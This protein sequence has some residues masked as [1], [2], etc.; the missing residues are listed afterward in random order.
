MARGRRARTNT[1]GTN[2]AEAQVARTLDHL[3]HFEDFTK[4]VLPKLQEAAMKG[5]TAEDIARL[6]GP[7][8][9]A[10]LASAAV[11][12]VDP[13]AALAM[14]REV[15]DRAYGKAGQKVE[16]TTRFAALSDAELDAMLKREL[17]AMK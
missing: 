11:T 15:L 9:M 10:K 12:E 7:V 14:V 17:E 2:V 16:Q 3:A 4:S 8:L 1:T 13:Q 6:A 5:K